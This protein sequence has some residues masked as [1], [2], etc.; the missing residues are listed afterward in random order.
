[1]RNINAVIF[2][3][4]LGVLSRN[5]NISKNAVLIIINPNIA[6]NKHPI[7]VKKNHLIF[8]LIIIS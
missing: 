6:P 5:P 1:M 3:P 2:S 4:Q 8:L 7:N